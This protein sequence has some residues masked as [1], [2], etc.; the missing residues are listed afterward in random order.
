MHKDKR[1]I[2]AE[3]KSYIQEYWSEILDTDGKVLLS[4]VCSNSI[5]LIVNLIYFKQLTLTIRLDHLKL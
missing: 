1:S 5:N 3:L 2:K 4:R